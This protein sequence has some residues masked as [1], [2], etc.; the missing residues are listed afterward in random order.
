MNNI[1]NEWTTRGNGK[2]FKFLINEKNFLRLKRQ[3]QT[4]KKKKKKLS[5][6]SPVPVKISAANEFLKD[7]VKILPKENI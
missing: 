2:I 7:W 6:I 5:Y 3:L 4:W 1:L